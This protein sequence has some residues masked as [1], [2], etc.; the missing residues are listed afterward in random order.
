MSTPQIILLLVALIDLILGGLISNGFIVIAIIREWTKSRSLVSSEYLLLSLALSNI[1]GTVL[2]TPFFI[3][4][5]IT[6]VF[7]S[8]CGLLIF[9]PLADFLI[10][11]RFWLTAWLCVFYCIKIV[12]ST[13]SLIL[14]CKLR[15]S[16]LLPRL[17]AGSLVVSL[18][19]VFYMFYSIL[20]KL[21]CITKMNDTKITPEMLLDRTVNT[22]E[23]WF[24]TVGSST[25][26]LVVMLCS[27]LVVASLCRHV[28]HMKGKELSSTSFQSKAHVKA[29]G[30]VLFLLF[31]YLSFYVVQTLCMTTRLGKTQGI[32]ATIVVMVYPT[33]QAYVLMLVNS[34]LNQAVTQ[35]LQRRET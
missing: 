33:A 9:Y 13:H 16:W 5:Y 31:H 24:L 22:P 2:I 17:L 14:W 30:T 26:L 29:A 3:N 20:R 27:I 8:N 19:I 18:F 23:V 32:I 21:Q 10:I 11:C 34:K 15:I 1:W 4:D 25:P 28:C 35:M 7:I 6:H 12:N